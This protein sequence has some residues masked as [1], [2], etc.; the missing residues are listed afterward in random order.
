MNNNEKDILIR[1]VLGRYDLYKLSGSRAKRLI[2]DPLHVLPFFILQF[3]SYIRPFT[4]NYR[5]LWG[6]K[7]SFYLPEGGMIYQYGFFEANLTNFLIRFLKEGDTFLDVG[8]HVGIYTMLASKLVGNTGKVYSFEPTPRTF[9]TLKNNSSLRNNITIYNNAVLNEIKQI[10]FFDYGPKFSAFNTFKK[11]EDKNIEFRDEVQKI[12]VN[13]IVL[14]DL[15][16]SQKITPTFIKIDA[17]GAEHLILQAMQNVIKNVKPLISIE[18]S[19]S[20]E[21]VYNSENSIKTLEDNGYVGYISKPDGKLLKHNKGQEYI[22]EN[23]IF[24]HNTKL[25]QIKSF[26]D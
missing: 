11:R 8:A 18:V 13:T 1:K 12:S 25:E 9:K 19:N 10:D 14:D 23:I 16:D 15:C 22:Y 4:V 5:T 17:E 26:I 24:V 20:P 2:K 3:L 7:M 6:D 21:F